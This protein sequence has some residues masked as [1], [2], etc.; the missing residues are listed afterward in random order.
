[1]AEGSRWTNGPYCPHCDSV[2]VLRMEGGAH[3]AGRFHCRDCRGQ[4]TVL[5]GSANGTQPYSAAQVGSDDPADDRT[6]PVARA[7]LR[8]RARQG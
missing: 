2:D 5:T 4:F 1:M 3:R 8:W 7:F 6:P